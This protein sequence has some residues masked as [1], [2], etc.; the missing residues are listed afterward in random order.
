MDSTLVHLVI[1]FTIGAAIGYL[2]YL[3]SGSRAE[4]QSIYGGWAFL[5]LFLFGLYHL[6]DFYQAGF[7]YPLA[8]GHLCG[9]GHLYL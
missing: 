2:T 4:R 3:L 5:P 7:T 6:P 1:F 8:D 9:V